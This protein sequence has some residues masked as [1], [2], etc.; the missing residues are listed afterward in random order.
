MQTVFNLKAFQ[1]K[2]NEYK[3]IKET[4]KVTLQNKT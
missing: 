2:V 1:Q 4:Q 3:K